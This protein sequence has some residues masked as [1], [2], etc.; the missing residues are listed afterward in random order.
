MLRGKNLS[1]LIDACWTYFF[2]FISWLLMNIISHIIAFR[3][4]KT[5]QE[6]NFLR[7]ELAAALHCNWM[8]AKNDWHGYEKV[9]CAFL[10]LPWSR[11][12]HAFSAQCCWHVQEFKWIRSEVWMTACET[13]FFCWDYARKVDVYVC[14][15]ISCIMISRSMLSLFSKRVIYKFIRKS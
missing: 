14:I 10:I 5:V 11:F 13:F 1:S 2:V 3:N 6:M 15:C 4:L 12:T 8:H 7:A 9:D